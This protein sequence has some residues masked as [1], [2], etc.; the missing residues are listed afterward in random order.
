MTYLN[1]TTQIAITAFRIHQCIQ[2][3]KIFFN[4]FNVKNINQYTRNRYVYTKIFL[5]DGQSKDSF[6][7]T[8]EILKY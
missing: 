7:Y 8:P 1:A 5:N 4:N 2:F 6:F 3:I